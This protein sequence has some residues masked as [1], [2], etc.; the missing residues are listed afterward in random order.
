M[1]IGFAMR[2]AGNR[3]TLSPS[4]ARE[5]AGTDIVDIREDIVSLLVHTTRS[6]GGVVD[7]EQ[8]FEL[9]ARMTRTT[10][11]Q[12]RPSHPARGPR[13]SGR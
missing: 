6:S 8:V 2:L 1:R 9:E 4:V 13:A 3:Y 7:L 11:A 10:S 12:P 5:G